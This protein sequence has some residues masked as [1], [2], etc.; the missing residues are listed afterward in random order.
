[1]KEPDEIFYKIDDLM[2]KGGRAEKD[3]IS[4]LGLAPG[5]YSQWRL[6]G[7]GRSYHKYIKEICAFLH[8]T[9]TE[10]F[11]GE[12]ENKN[13]SSYLTEEERNI[14]DLFRKLGPTERKYTV[15]VMNA[16]AE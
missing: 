2:K 15:K 9:P 16:L 6:G 4:Y 3:L 8:V 11:I 12:E 14:I 10:L 7:H 5:T 13:I 1:M